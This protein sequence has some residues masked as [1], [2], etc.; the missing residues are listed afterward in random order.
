MGQESTD[1]MMQRSWNPGGGFGIVICNYNIIT[2]VL[3]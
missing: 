2:V 1:K 3:L